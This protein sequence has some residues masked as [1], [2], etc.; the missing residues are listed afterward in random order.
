MFEKYA[1]LVDVTRNKLSTENFVLMQVP[2][3]RNLPKNEYINERIK[4][5]N[6][7]INAFR[8][9]KNYKVANVYDIIKAMPNYDSL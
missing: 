5:F 1:D 3:I 8:R 2:P 9:D 7:Q 4:I 6:H